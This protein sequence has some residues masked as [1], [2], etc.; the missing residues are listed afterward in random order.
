MKG[1]GPKSSTLYIDIDAILLCQYLH[2]SRMV[3]E[4]CCMESGPLKHNTV[5][6]VYR[7]SSSQKSHHLMHMTATGGHIELLTQ[8]ITTVFSV[9]GK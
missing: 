6:P 4:A 3:A 8:I 2:Y 9:D 7:S 1:S 5:P